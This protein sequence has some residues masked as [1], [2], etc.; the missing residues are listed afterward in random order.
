MHVSPCQCLVLHPTEAAL[1][2]LPGP[3]ASP[4]PLPPPHWARGCARTLADGFCPQ[5]GPCAQD[6][7]ER[8]EE[9]DEGGPGALPAPTPGPPGQLFAPKT[10]VLVSRL[11]HVEVFRVRRAAG[12][13]G[14]PWGALAGWTVIPSL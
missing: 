6:G 14:Q 2:S 3:S 13:P 11:D 5:E 4:G 10:L 9:A 8:D 7:A 1:S 12:S